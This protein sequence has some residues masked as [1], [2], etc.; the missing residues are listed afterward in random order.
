MADV[1]DRIAAL[2]QE[3]RTTL[4]FVNTRSL[5]ERFA[6]QLG[7][8]LGDDVVAAHHGSLSKDRRYR[9]EI[10]ACAPAT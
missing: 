7:E 6:H 3:H 10:A 9:V 4:V 2:V 1:L 5:A 8:R